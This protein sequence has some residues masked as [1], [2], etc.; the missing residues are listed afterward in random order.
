MPYSIRED[1]GRYCVYKRDEQLKCYD[2][3]HEA[4]DYLT[5]LEIHA[6][7]AETIHKYGRALS[8]ANEQ[9]I[10]SAVAAL[11][12]VLQRAGINLQGEPMDEKAIEE[13]LKQLDPESAQQLAD[14]VNTFV[15]TLDSEL[16]ITETI[17][18]QEQPAD[19]DAPPDEE[20]SGEDEQDPNAQGEQQP[21]EEE[22]DPTKKPPTKKQYWLFQDEVNYTPDAIGDKHCSS[23]RWFIP[24]GEFGGSSC[25][26]VATYPAPIVP[27]GY[28]E[29]HEA[30]PVME[31]EDMAMAAVE[32]KAAEA[33]KEENIIQRATH[34]VMSMLNK[35]L[36]DVDEPAAIFSSFQVFKA[37]GRY[38]WLA[39]HTNN[40]ED[41]DQEIL[42]GKSHDAYAARVGMGL[43]DKPE[44]W[45]WHSKGS[46]IG[47][48]DEVWTHRPKDYPDVCFVFA[49]GHFDDDPISQRAAKTLERKQGSVELSHGFTYPPYALKNGVYEI[50]NTFEISVL[51]QGMA[52]NPYTSFEEIQAMALSDRQRQWIKDTGGDELLARVER[53]Q[54][55]SEK[56]GETLKALDK[57]YKDFAD[58]IQDKG[59]DTMNVDLKAVLKVVAE[60]IDAQGAIEA[61]RAT[62]KAAA[63]SALSKIEA[64]QATIDAL[65]ARLDLRPRS[66]PRAKETE[67]EGQN[68]LAEALKKV[69]DDEYEVHPT[70]GR[71]KPR[72]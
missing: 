25:T 40:F 57:R 52:A 12:S 17:Q 30:L 5:A 14:L 2:T 4:M 38:L 37:G 44:L 35:A 33:R 67:I 6:K 58:A 49:L 16:G 54:S 53:A 11:I 56:D 21:R 26:I 63:D 59:T 43:V 46:R 69:N 8:R 47:Q 9:E 24:T 41:R 62:E 64:M 23:C 71:L 22:Q 60:L 61:E 20:Q 29:R 27:N 15:Q 45:T 10:T 51:P 19:E 72:S 70:W 66:A 18:E 65:N 39:R 31:H 7:T 55:E 68:A 42:S 36:D 32:D 34:H 3:K 13:R 48:A 1:N 50:Y 28:C